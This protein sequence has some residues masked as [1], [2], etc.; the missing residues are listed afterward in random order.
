MSV[1]A[2]LLA[3]GLLLVQGINLNPVMLGDSYAS[4]TGAGDYSD[5]LCGRSSHAAIEDVGRFF[6]VDVTNAA[7]SGALVED[8]EGTRII[9]ERRLGSDCSTDLVGATAAA[10][11]NA[12]V[13]T[14]PPQVESV[15]GA[16][17]VFVTIGGN[18]VGFVQIAGICLIQNSETRC[19]NALEEAAETVDD[20]MDEQRDALLEIRTIAPDARIHIVPYPRILDV[21]ID[22]TI[23]SLDVTAEVNDLQEGWENDLRQLADEL[24]DEVGGVFYVETLTPI[25]EGH[26][27][28]S[29]DSWILTSGRISGLLHPSEEGW[30]ATG[31]A[32]IAHL[33]LTASN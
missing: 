19:A 17:D 7:C 10:T 2:G 29:D 5:D 13:I 6:G 24:D 9:D 32:N 1:V 12:C 30:R 11:G 4:G 33:G 31:T 22:H 25:W 3:A 28:G 21:G 23:G 18:N 8:L 26:G 15:S 14:L 20:V 16:T 27:L